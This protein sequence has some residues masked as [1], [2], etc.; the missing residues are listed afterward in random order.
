[1]EKLSFLNFEF[2]FGCLATCITIESGKVE[3]AP[4][5]VELDERFAKVLFDFISK[6]KQQGGEFVPEETEM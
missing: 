4:L 1:M 3:M 6:P 2:L 5:D